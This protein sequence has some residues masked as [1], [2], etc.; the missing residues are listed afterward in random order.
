MDDS[1]FPIT[2]YDL[3]ILVRFTE[4]A[5][6]DRQPQHF[7]GRQDRVDCVGSQTPH[8]AEYDTCLTTQHI[9]PC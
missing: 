7:L 2:I 8:E 1:P 9:Y 3:C 4:R 5:R 6:L